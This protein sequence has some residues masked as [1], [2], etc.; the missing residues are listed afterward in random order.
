MFLGG[1]SCC[2]AMLNTAAWLSG[3]SVSLV[4]RYI[5]WPSGSS[6]ARA[7]MIPR[8]GSLPSDAVSTQIS[9]RRGAGG[10]IDEIGACLAASGGVVNVAVRYR[11]SNLPRASTAS[12]RA[13]LDS[14]RALLLTQMLKTLLQIQLQAKEESDTC[15]Q[16][17]EQRPV[18]T[19]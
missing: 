11:S 6:V 17:D 18:E 13:C 7:A 9:T 2:F 15:A 3:S 8:R 10:G 12:F 4:H 16:L 1:N 14:P 19:L 5:D